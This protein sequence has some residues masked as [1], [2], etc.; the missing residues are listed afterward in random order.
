MENLENEF[1]LNQDLINCLDASDWVEIL[2]SIAISYL[3]FLPKKE[4]IEA[5][6]EA[7]DITIKYNDG[8][9]NNI[10]IYSSKLCWENFKIELNI[11]GIIISRQNGHSKFEELHKL[12][13]STVRTILKSK[14]CN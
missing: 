4:E 1:K 2:K 8:N 12:P 9:I 10:T 11:T 5:I 14:L 6:K 7:N 13:I 3:Y